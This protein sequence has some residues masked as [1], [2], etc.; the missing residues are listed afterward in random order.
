MVNYDGLYNKNFYGKKVGQNH[1]S[2]QK[3]R[4]KVIENGTI[5]PHK[6]IQN[7][8]T[9][10]GGILDADGNYLEESFVHHGVTEI[11]TPEEEIILSDTTVIYFNM[12]CHIW[13]HCLTD[14]LRRV[15]FFHSDFYKKYFK[16]LP[17]VYVP[18]WQGILPS[19]AEL[20]SIL[21]IDPSRLI[22]STQPTRFKE[23]ILPDE[24]F[25]ETTNK[26]TGEQEVFFTK[27]Y[28]ET[29]QRVRDYGEKNFVPLSQK[30]FYF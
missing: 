27:E 19:F 22:P 24:S 17:I 25:F 29:I 4:F 14:S 16:N 30:K 11:Y 9:G 6:S 28:Q 1:L 12:I 7:Y 23:I 15:W 8:P 5:L 20:L 18:M 26:E 13:G 21:E 10:L 2:E 3:L